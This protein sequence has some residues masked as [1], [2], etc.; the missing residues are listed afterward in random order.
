MAAASLIAAEPDRGWWRPTLITAI[1]TAVVGI[2]SFASFLW[3]S[4]AA[5]PGDPAVFRARIAHGFAA[6]DLVEDPFQEGSTTIGSHQ[7]ND[8][9]I[10]VMAMDQRGDPARLALSPILMD[11]GATPSVSNNPCAVLSAL[12][13]G[14]TPNGN[15]YYYDNYP[16]GAVVLLRLL[17]P[18]REIERIRADYRNL[19]SGLLVASLALVMVGLASG[20]NMRAFAAIGVTS[21]ALMR[22]FGLESF[23]Q[24][25]G[26]GPA[27]AV[28][29]AYTL[30]LAAMAFRPTGL[31]LAVVAAAVC[32]AL[33]MIFELFTGGVPLGLAMVIGLTPLVVRPAV[34]PTVA[35]G[36]SA[37]AFLGAGA[38]FYLL[39]MVAVVMIAGGGIAGNAVAEAFRLTIFVP[40]GVLKDGTGFAVAIRETFHSVDTLTGGMGLMS[41]ATIVIG[42]AAG[43][44]GFVQVRRNE[45]SAA[46]RSQ[47]LMLALSL[48][49]PPLW[50]VFFLNL[51]INHA[52]FTDRIFVWLIAGGFSLFFLSLLSPGAPR[53]HRD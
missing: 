36:A 52:W 2:I 33:T 11:F 15:L 29:A 41:A 13:Q 47:A 7:W 14:A 49:I 18:Y 26:H 17:L 8:C 10:I 51:M 32:G 34:R 27:D 28:L 50:C 24:S 45:P 31:G 38:I 16:H 21:V 12:N 40:N 22:Y 48:I 6:G 1:I 44:Y 42:L 30:A 43:A 23:S 53:P 20:R 9:L 4:T 46:V 19:L 39:K 25:L 3:A 5:L 35:A 37:A